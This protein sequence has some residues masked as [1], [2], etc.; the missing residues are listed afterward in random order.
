MLKNKNKNKIENQEFEHQSLFETVMR[1]NNI[2]LIK[3]FVSISLLANI[4]ALGLLL[5]GR[6]SKHFTI[7]DIIIELSLIAVILI[8]AHLLAKKIKNVKAASYVVLTAVLISIW[9]FQ[10][11]MY[12]TKELSAAPYIALALSIFYFNR[13]IS[14]YATV[15]VIISQVILLL[16]R[17]TLIPVSL[18]GK[19]LA[20]ELLV[21][22]LT[23]VWV[24]ISASTGAAATNMLMNLAIN[25]NNESHENISKLREV[26]IAITS[27]IRT[28]RG[29]SDEQNSV[30]K[31][32]NSISQSQAASMEEIA[33][34]QEEN[35]ANSVSISESAKSVNEELAVTDSAINDLKLV[36]D[37]ALISNQGISDT[38]EEVTKYSHQSS[39]QIIITTDRIS[40][41]N[42]H[43][44]EMANFIQIINDISDQINLLS[45]NAAIEAARAGDAGRG[46]AVVADEISKLA[47]ATTENA[48][49]IEK[50]IVNNQELIE[51][52]SVS[53]K[54]TK[55]NI[56]NLTSSID[57]IKTQLLDISDLITD[58][59]MTIK[60]VR[61]LNSKVFESSKIIENATMEQKQASDLSSQTTM[62]VSE[63]AQILSELAVK[64]SHGADNISSIAQELDSLSEKMK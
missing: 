39:E 37:K 44:N 41:L 48:R 10:Y 9:I 50:I 55:D 40:R 3:A 28:M 13:K 8:T 18:E 21:R 42:T 51:E 27:S 24:G 17:P 46:F 34:A 16:L 23:Y 25:K 20:N 49:N 31:E 22:F 12:G 64:I 53:V 2:R 52:S 11:I 14:I 26:A 47:D 54:D 35:S 5:S 61:N 19:I 7:S 32:L 6:G 30:I 15:F 4:A 1:Q 62:E 43:S 38:I 59:D 57:E 45:L 56:D 60:T 33:A 58:I 36:N 29:N 63:T